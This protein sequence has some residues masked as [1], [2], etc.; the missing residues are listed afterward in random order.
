MWLDRLSGHS[1]PSGSPSPYNNRNYPPP[2]RRPSHLSPNP[3]SNR[4]GISP[5]SSSLT[6]LSTPNDS[7]TS[8]PGTSRA[9]NGVSQKQGASSS[10]PLGVLDPLDVLNSIIGKKCGENG[11]TD[12][13]AEAKPAQKPAQLV[14]TID[15]E[16][17]SLEEFVSKKDETNVFL[18]SEAGAQTIQQCMACPV[19]SNRLQKLLIQYVVEK[20][21]D[22]FQDLHNSITVC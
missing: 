1:T 22:K 7:T 16:G 12:L 18:K 20:E 11:V 21:R 3:S 8:L 14:D 2:S 5:R 10:R 4:P 13:D 15:F 9:S 17:R 19:R 6:L